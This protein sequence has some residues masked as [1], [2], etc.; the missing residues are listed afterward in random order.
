MFAVVNKINANGYNAVNFDVRS[1]QRT[2][3]C[4]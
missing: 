2:A 1:M 4:V 3:Y